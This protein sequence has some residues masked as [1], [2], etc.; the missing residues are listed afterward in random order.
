MSDDNV[1]WFKVSVSVL[2]NSVPSGVGG[3]KE[4]QLLPCTILAS[5]GEGEGVVQG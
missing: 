3:M 4:T 5:C 2:S 1:L